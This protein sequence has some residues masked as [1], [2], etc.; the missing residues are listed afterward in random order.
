[1]MK[2]QKVETIN[3]YKQVKPVLDVALHELETKYLYLKTTVAYFRGHT[4]N[5]KSTYPS[6]TKIDTFLNAFGVGK[7]R[8]DSTYIKAGS[9]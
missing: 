2:D 8:G 1:M 9:R 6:H 7:A 3:S 4:N 5:T